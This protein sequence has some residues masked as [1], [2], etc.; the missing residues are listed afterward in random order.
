MGKLIIIRGNSGSGKSTVARDLQERL[1]YGTALIE[2]DYIRR[3]VLREWDKPGQPNIELIALNAQ[4]AMQH[5]HTVIV[6]GIL[7][8]KHYGEMLAGLLAEF[9]SHAVYYFDIP[10]EETFRRHATKPN[11]HEFGEEQMREWYAPQDMLGIFNERIVDETLSREQIV[12]TI[13]KD[14]A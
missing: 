12:E 7:P 6:E 2:Q 4:F 11:A 13:I 3:K 10:L 8:K 1:G 9:P 5:C 14:I